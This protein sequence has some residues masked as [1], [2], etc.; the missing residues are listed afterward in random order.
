[1]LVIVCTGQQQS[2][3]IPALKLMEELDDKML[4]QVAS[5]TKL[6]GATSNAYTTPFCIYKMPLTSKELVFKKD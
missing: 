3:Q 2:N 6:E 4:L 1:M 5:E